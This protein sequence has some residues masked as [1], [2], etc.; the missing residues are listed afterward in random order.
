MNKLLPALLVVVLLAAITPAWSMPAF[1]GMLFT[2]DGI[3][4]TSPW[5]ED[6]SISWDISQQA[7]GIWSYSYLLSSVTGGSLGKDPSHLI[8][9]ISENVGALSFWDITMDGV[10]VSSLSEIDWFS[11]ANPSNPLMPGPMYG[12]KINTPDG[13][14]GSYTYSFL[15][16][17]APVWGDFYVKDGKLCQ[18]DVV[19]Y[20]TDFLLAD[21]L[22]PAQNG[23]LQDATGA[24]IYKILRPD[25]QTVIPE[26]TTLSLLGLGLIGLGVLRRKGV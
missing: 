2:P 7:G 23:L 21:P 14:T 6:F 19:A 10:D 18:Q 20:N 8:I 9:E 17:R 16:D 15:S 5:A 1:S 3:G 11:A 13:F 26:P 12:L 25:T 4:G 22:D 24:Y